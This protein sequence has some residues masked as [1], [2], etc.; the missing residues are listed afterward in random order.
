MSRDGDRK[1]S[2]QLGESIKSTFSL[3]ES[4][5][6]HGEGTRS[7][8]G[9]LNRLKRGAAVYAIKYSVPLVPVG[10]T[11]PK[12]KWHRSD[13]EVS[14]GRPLALPQY[15]AEFSD[16]PLSPDGFASAVT[17][18]AENSIAEMTGQERSGY[19][20]DPYTKKLLIPEEE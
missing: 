15:G 7:I 9:R 1:G 2:V 10:I 6:L 12:E 17:N 16:V 8:D 11:Y 4:L 5:L 14:F 3:G 19:H 20:L 13:I 18:I